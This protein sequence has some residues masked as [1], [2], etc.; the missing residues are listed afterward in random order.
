MTSRNKKSKPTLLVVDDEPDN[1]D[2]LYRTFYRDYQVLR[3]ESGPEALDILAKV[4][5]VAVI[6]SDQ[7]MPQMSGT[8]F[9]GLTATQYPDTIRIILT[10]YTDV[11]DLVEAI[12]SGKVF[13]YVT[14]PWKADELKALVKQALDTHNVLK[15]RTNDLRRALQQE[16]L[17][18]AVTNTIRSA[19]N[20]RQMLQRIVETVGQM[21]E[22]SVAV[23]RPFQD[24]QV[25]EEWFVYQRQESKGGNGE[26]ENSSL[27]GEE[28]IGQIVWET[29]DVEVIPDVE[30]DDRFQEDS[31]EV[32][33]RKEV[34]LSAGIRSSLVVPL[35]YRLDLTAVL[36][37]HQ[38]DRLR[39]WE[40]QEVQLLIT[41]ADQAA[42]ALSQAIAYEQ[43]QALAQR[44]AL[45]NSITGAIR[46]SLDP[47]NIFA[48]ITEK[49]GE[50]LGVDGC[51]L[52]LWTEEDEYVQCVGL[53]DASERSSVVSNQW[54]EKTPTE[55]QAEIA[56]RQPKRLPSSDFVG[57]RMPQSVAPIRGN[58]VLLQLL[59]S[60]QPVA[61][62]DLS[63]RPE[64]NV[65]ELPLRSSARALLVVPLIYDGKII[66]SISLRHNKGK[67]RWLACDRLLKVVLLVGDRGAT[68]PPLSNYSPTSRTT[69]RSRSP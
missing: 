64:L 37:L 33:Q 61:V 50:A 42:L 24:N 45:V 5:E 4:G 6:I 55:R 63:E 60:K 20:Y 8:E 56:N 32:Q 2:L 40:G 67:H 47:K 43:A 52:S 27:I 1:L 3:A 30:T 18:Y 28:L 26:E 44:E 29:T 34:L 68:I 31:P 66:G 58:P 39:Y 9:L 53:Y 35:F 11:E 51:A 23:C 13:K 59:E 15:A 54:S 14:K 49:L 36:A 38:R 7:R 25:Q 48:A 41:V 16:S 57:G 22:A 69:F 46:S 12:N 17:L 62:S 65:T 19:P 21:F 10:G